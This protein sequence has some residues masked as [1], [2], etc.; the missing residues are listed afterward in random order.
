V[1]SNIPAM[2][3]RSLRSDGEPERENEYP[4][5]SMSG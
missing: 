5:G 1:R 2:E 4:R 3:D